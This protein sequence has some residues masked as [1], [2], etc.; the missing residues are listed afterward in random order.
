MYSFQTTVVNNGLCAFHVYCRQIARF[1][2]HCLRQ[3]G[4]LFLGQIHQNAEA[5]TEIEK[6]EIGKR[7]CSTTEQST[8]EASLFVN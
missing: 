7:E 2:R 4:R 6:L 8:D 5:K 3:R 1:L